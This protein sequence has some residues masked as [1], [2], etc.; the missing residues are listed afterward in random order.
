MEIKDANFTDNPI[1]KWNGTSTVMT[2]LNNN[3]SKTTLTEY[4]WNVEL[5]NSITRKLLNES[6]SI[7]I[8]FQEACEEDSITKEL[9]LTTSHQ[10]RA[11]LQSCMI[12]I[13]EKLKREKNKE[14]IDAMKNQLDLYSILEMLWHI[15]E[16]LF[17]EA[18]GGGYCLQELLHWVKWH[19]NDV[20]QL[21]QSVA[22]SDDPQSH[23]D[24]WP[25]IYG[26]VAQCRLS[27]VV[28]LLS[29]HP[30][31][32][33]GRYD[34][35][36]NI[37]EL[38]TKMPKFEPFQGQSVT[39]FD[40][41]WRIWQSECESRLQGGDFDD[42]PELKIIAQLLTGDESE[43][44]KRDLCSTWYQLMVYKL[45]YCNPTVRTF[46]IKQCAVECMEK[47]NG[48][49][50]ITTLDEIILSIVSL[51]VHQVLEKCSEWLSNWWFVSHLAD[52][53][54]H[55][56]LLRSY[57]LNYGGD[58]REFLLLEYGATL[59]SH[60][61]LWSIAT[62]YFMYCEKYG[63]AHF[64][65][66]IEKIPLEN[67]RKAL[68]VINV[69][70]KYGFTEQSFAICKVMGLQ[71]LRRK[72]Y[73]VALSWCLRANDEVFASYLT[74]QFLNHYM[75]TGT[76]LQCDLIDNLGSSMLLSNKLTFLG[77][78][79]EFHKLYESRRFKEAAKLLVSLLTSN[80]APR[81]FWMILLIDSLPLLQHDEVIFTY[82]QTFELMQSFK[83]LQLCHQLNENLTV[84]N[85][86]MSEGEKDQTSLINLALC[87]NLSRAI[88]IEP[89][90]DEPIR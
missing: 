22:A 5:D 16:A 74:D 87:R 80:L 26:L 13:K 23:P 77:K 39:E 18:D 82:D 68:K 78:Y 32:E 20:D 88:L 57:D 63:R 76:F 44:L 51:D 15:C 31:K 2:G 9:L 37:E 47:F 84:K 69:C 43:L 19:F 90:N 60:T 17:I 27:E 71:A 3:R 14:V 70:E 52:L 83:E 41:K 59:M 72:R 40:E 86:V 33:Q 28:D 29:F 58:L 67:E 34:V 7:F 89:S 73:G 11:V 21:A 8:D 65:K 24:Y 38:L 42:Y 75:D 54:F 12:K 46:N 49:G 36:A 30:Y 56:N 85:K 53:L 4:K 66:Y 81:K 35:F 79:Y 50:N 6:H 10:Y 61:S 62:D 55:C 45:Q 64:E 25:T 1:V 48:V